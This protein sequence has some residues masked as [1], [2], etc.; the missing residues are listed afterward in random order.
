MRRVVLIVCDGLGRNWLGR[1]HT[2]F[3]DGLLRSGL[4]ARDHRAVF[5]SVT[6]VSAASIATGCHPGVHGLH[7]NQV[8]LVEQGALVVSDVGKP[9]F[10]DHLRGVT[11][12]ALHVPTLADRLAVA[13][14]CQVAYSNVS[15][16]AAYFLDPE[17]SGWVHHRS[18]SFG[19]GGDRLSGDGHLDVSHDLAGDRV[20]SDRFGEEVVPRSD[21]ALGIL[22]LA[23]PDLT[24]HHSP[25]GSP[26][27]LD[28][29]QA[30]DARVAEVIERVQRARGRDDI[31]T[32][33]CSDHGHETVASSVHVGE[34]LAGQGLHDLLS[35]GCVAV[36]SQGT[37]ALLYATP[38][39]RP[40]LLRTLDEMARQPWAGRVVTE[41]ELGRLGIAGA[42]ALVAAVDTRRDEHA[43]NP[44]GTRGARWLVADGEKPPAIGCGHHGGLGPDETRPFLGLVHPDLPA[45]EV[46]QATSL[47]DIA[48][49]LLHF[50]GH[51]AEGMQGRSLLG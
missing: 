36:A 6:R 39:G 46:A 7:G 12:R 2:P 20:M 13:G 48:P 47:V 8:A 1:G 34:W 28:A 43:R 23:N 45:G 42:E 30:T 35:R 32:V 40:A 31:L 49:T 9:G 15:A 16:G 5:P 27:H 50:L 14:L 25:L 26:A 29:L 11:G 51:P 37:A 38:E 18:G 44:H 10:L 22:W 4:S 41:S 33:I 21:V 24:L 19:P 17:H 3:I